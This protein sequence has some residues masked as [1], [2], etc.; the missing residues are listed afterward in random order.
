MDDYEHKVGINKVSIQEEPQKTRKVHIEEMGDKEEAPRNT[1][2]PK[3]MD[4]SIAEI[5][6]STPDPIPRNRGERIIDFFHFENHSKRYKKIKVILSVLSNNLLRDSN[7]VLESVSDL[8]CL[9]INK[10]KADI[11]NLVSHVE[12]LKYGELETLCHSLIPNIASCCLEAPKYFP[13][14]SPILILESGYLRSLTLSRY[15]VLVL[16]S[17]SF[18]GLIPKTGNDSLPRSFLISQL[19]YRSEKGNEIKLEKIK[20]IFGYFTE[21]FKSE[22]ETMNNQ[23]I[24]FYRRRLPAGDHN[25]LSYWT[26]QTAQMTEVEFNDHDR[27]EDAK[28]A[29]QIDF[30]NR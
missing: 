19:F 15:Q 27:I 13:E 17:L 26:S 2:P 24:T 7:S 3:K 1:K 6:A 25:L 30:A 11:S 4:K 12:T 22:E 8:V 5:I 29:V 14:V 16:L 10:T 23:Q 9:G 28:D 18:F 20:F 21:M